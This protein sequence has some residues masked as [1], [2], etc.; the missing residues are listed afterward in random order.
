MGF[1]GLVDQRLNFLKYIFRAIYL[2]VHLWR[3]RGFRHAQ[4]EVCHARVCDTSNGKNSLT[5]SPRNLLRHPEL[6]C[7]FLASPLSSFKSS[8]KFYISTFYNLSKPHDPTNHH[9]PKPRS[10][11]LPKYT[12]TQN[13]NIHTIPRPNLYLHINSATIYLQPRH[14][15]YP[16]PPENREVNP[17]IKDYE[18]CPTNG[19]DGCSTEE[20]DWNFA[21]W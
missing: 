11:D 21:F 7:I 5:Q 6:F 2:R 16:R 15:T 4:I 20:E 12:E 13:P 10:N 3:D 19:Y 14:P 9:F 8:L 18:S 1:P 17:S